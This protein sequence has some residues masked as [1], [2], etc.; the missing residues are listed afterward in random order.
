MKTAGTILLVCAVLVAAGCGSASREATGA[1]Q[2][3]K[4]TPSINAVNSNEQKTAEAP[5]SQTTAPDALVKDLYKQHDADKGPFFQKKN[6]ALVD[7]YF[8]REF[9][10]LIWEDATNPKVETG[11]FDAD[12]LYNSQD[13][14]PKNFNVGAP[15]VDNDRADV[16]AS[17]VNY[18]E[19]QTVTFS[20]ARQGGDW[21]ITDIKYKDGTSLLKVLNESYKQSAH[22]AGEFEGT[23]QV[24][25]TTCV[26]KPVKMA[27]EVRWAKGSGSMLFFSEEATR[28]VSEDTGK[29]KD[30][31]VFDNESLD[32]GKF[33]RADGKESPIRRIK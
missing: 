9:A 2:N 18:N 14:Q 29:G 26:V 13:P 27:Y 10:D 1:S 6:R 24:G 11:A 15:K 7:K 28:F 16:V 4:P 21:K 5:A 17:F 25:E 3:A 32:A 8:A 12:P 23:Y 31:F 19:K 33:V 20:L 30:A 22:G